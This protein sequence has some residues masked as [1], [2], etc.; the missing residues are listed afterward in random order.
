MQSIDSVGERK[1]KMKRKT[2]DELDF[3]DDYMF[4]RILTSNL[5]LT[6]NLLELIL[7][8]PIKK[9]QVA[10]AQKSIKESY[11]GKGIRLD[12]YVEDDNNTIYDVEMQT[13]KQADIPKRTRYYQGMIDMFLINKGANYKELKKSYVI[14]ICLDDIFDKSRCVYTFENRCIEDTS[15]RLDDESTKVL[16]NPKGCRDGLS[17]D[18]NDFLDFLMGEEAQSEFTREIKAEVTQA[19]KREDWRSDY[20]TLEMIRKEERE[21]GRTE[22]VIEGR[23]KTI[24]EIVLE[25]DYSLEKGAEKAGMTIPELKEKAKE[26]GY[27]L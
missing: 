10:E 15:I 23:L 27:E 20:M 19:R 16:I 1:K 12:V 6:K 18:M 8:V 13:T 4:C 21:E 11:D 14:F 24:I 3:T 7:N 25:G 22:G 9:V 26:F 17:E 2:Y 5:S